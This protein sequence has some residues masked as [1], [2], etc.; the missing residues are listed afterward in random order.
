[1]TVETQLDTLEA[2]G[3][4]RL[5]AYQPELE[6][7]FRHWLVQDAAYESL[8]KQERRELHRLVGEAIETLY[9]ERRKELAGILAMHFDAAGDADKAI[10]YHVAAGGYALERNA[11]TEAYGAFDRAAALL[12]PTADLEPEDLRRRRIEVGLG[13]ARAGFPFRPLEELVDGLEG[14]LPDAEALGDPALIARVHMNVAL[15]RLQS[16]QVVSDPNIQRSLDRVGEIG[17]VL[18][19]PSLAALPLALVGMNRIFKGPI[20]DGVQKLEQAVPQ[21][22]KREDF[23]GSAFAR[24]VLAIGHA[25]LGNFEKAEAAASYASEL[26]V[27]GDVIAQ[28]DALIAGSWVSSARGRLDKAV[29][30]A[31]TCLL[32]SE[33]TGATA[34]MVASS[35]ILGDAYQRQ[36]RFGEAKETLRR[37]RDIALVADRQMFW[38]TLHAWLVSVSAALGDETSPAEWDEALAMARSIG[39]RVGEEGILR[40]RAEVGARRAAATAAEG[41]AP[42]DAWVPALADFAVSAGIA[43]EL[44]AR[45]DLAR[46]LRSWGEALR[47][48]G[49]AAE[50]DER[51]RLVADSDEKLRRALDLFEEMGI[52]AEAESIRQELAAAS[53]AGSETAN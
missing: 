39:N 28:L 50:G 38:P 37:G 23:I 29:P 21:L 44:G 5:A 15:M 9:P 27:K 4:I 31:Q 53:K 16:G 3:L 43:E 46:I 1:V 48:A 13:R 8:L 47:T 33:E 25:M 30:L 7:L 49:R 20:R 42:A 6:Y 26:A 45:P 35:W 51:S 19:D 11:I 24:G 17:E 22:E 12:P 18:N 40:K 10:G 2:K 41:K 52:D 14:V 32:K 36:G 34:C